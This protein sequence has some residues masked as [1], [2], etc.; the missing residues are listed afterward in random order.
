MCK[1]KSKPN[2]GGLSLDAMPRRNAIFY[3]AHY[4]S[5]N[6][7]SRIGSKSIERTGYVHIQQETAAAVAVLG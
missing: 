1:V 2:N 4:C 7:K 5:P 3:Y 6:N